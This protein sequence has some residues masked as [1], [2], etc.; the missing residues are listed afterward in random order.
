[1]ARCRS[2]ALSLSLVKYAP[3]SIHLCMQPTY[4]R[5]RRTPARMHQPYDDEMRAPEVSFRCETEM[6]PC[7]IIIRST[8]ALS[9]QRGGTRKVANGYGE[10]VW[11]SFA[12]WRQALA[13]GV[14][15]CCG[16]RGAAKGTRARAIGRRSKALCKCVL[17]GRH[18]FATLRKVIYQWGVMVEG[19]LRTREKSCVIVVFL[20][21]LCGCNFR[22][23]PVFK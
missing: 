7:I 22:P 23:F 12:G 20:S 14:L 17:G 5:E 18:R 16:G 11:G 3:L 15:C 2:L 9:Q 13:V 1:M 21:F 6:Q 10:F 8:P 19:G 4:R